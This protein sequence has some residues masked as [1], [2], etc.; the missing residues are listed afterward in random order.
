MCVTCMSKTCTTLTIK[1]MRGKLGMLKGEKSS[2][3]PEL[4]SL[5]K[6]FEQLPK[7][8]VDIVKNSLTYPFFHFFILS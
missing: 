6:L 3:I 1:H 7:H 5:V 4:Q 2:P 8:L